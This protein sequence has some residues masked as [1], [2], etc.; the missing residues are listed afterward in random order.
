MKPSFALFL[1]LVASAHAVDFN[2][3]VRPVLAQQCF[4]CHGM[5]DHARKGK[6]RLDLS[7]SA[8]GKGKSGEIAIIPGKPDASE[9]IKRILST[10]EDEVMPP[11]HT[12]KVMSDKDKA[13]LKAWIAEGAKYQAHWAYSAPKQ[14]PVPSS[15]F[16]V[17]GSK[18][19]EPQETRNKKP[20]THPIDAFIHGRLEKEGLKPSPEAAAYTLVRRVYLDLIGLPP[21]PAE[22]D[23]FV[24]QSHQSPG[25]HKPYE[26]LVDT[27]LASKH[28]GERWAR[29]WLDLARYA[30]TNGFEKDRPRQIW[31][32]RDWVV[33]ALND[34]MPFDQFS[35]KQIAGDMLPKASAEDLIATGFHRNTMLNEEGGIDPNEY[36]FYAMVDR[37]GVTGTAWMGLTLNCCQCHTHKYDPILH[38]DYYSVMALLNNADEPL[39]HIPTPDIEAQQKAHAAKIAQLEAELPKKF[40]GGEAAMQ[41]RFAGW[42]EGESKRASKWQIVRPAAMK[43]TM[44]HLEQQT[45]GFILGSGDISKSDVYDLNLKAPIKGVTALRIEVASHPSLPND[46]PGLTNYEGPLGGFFLSEL[47]AFQN[48]QRVKITRAEATNDEEEDR[49]NDQSAAK[50]KAKAKAAAKPRKTNNA[51]AALDAEMSS[52]WQVLGGIGV[53]HAAVFHFEKPID[54]TSG[55]DLK[56][57]FEK[58]FACPLGH[59]RISVTT[60][61]HAIATGHPLEVEEALAANDSSKRE[62]LLRRFLETAP[63]MKQVTAPL[64]AARKNPP[65]G[66]PTLVMSERPASNPRPTNRYHRGEYLSP[67]ET[68]P[69]AVP[70][71]LP[72]LPK[73]APANRLTFAK[74]LFAPEN[75]LTARV[76]VNRQWQAFFG[77]G[78]VKSLEDFGYQSEPP[79]HPEL[80][81]WLAVEF[82]E[83]GWSMKKLHRLIVT[84]ATYK[85]SSRITPELAQ[86]DPENILLA[87]G[88]RF[89]LDA[90][91]I[92][93]SALK[94]AGVLSPKMGGPGVYPPQPASITSEGTYGK[95]EWKTSEGEDRY[96]RS[97]YTFIKRTAPFAMSTTFDAPTGE[98]CL[99]KRDVSN[100]PLQALTLLNDQ[101]FMEAAQAMAKAVIAESQDDDTRLQNIFRRCTTRPVAADELAML[102]TFL[103]KQRDQKLEGEALWAAV[104]RA[105]LNLDESITHP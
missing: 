58:H 17:S 88:A 97:L 12:K 76:T 1:L 29:R 5:D 70:A 69:P 31:P 85:Q 15:K 61:D 30:D 93:D 23:A 64:L 47:Q 39:Y 63:E 92:R 53:Q 3:D 34:D 98:A 22:A 77:R 24:H 16:Q 43:T 90:E 104:S 13:T 87:R 105:A 56:M 8:H 89:R 68:V 59:F 7:E 9:V 75:S 80:L 2:R 36:R 28:Y 91:I 82:V 79:S 25:S 67:K 73:D 49:I 86:R 42:I 81:D 46:G 83:L 33:K 84:S 72:S 32:Y 71:F 10:D 11:P 50:P 52:G 102:K 101:M 65:R 41:S 27:L 4:T 20:E 38:T 37:V 19:G 35:I 78:L 66:Q 99:A 51:S 44:P 54:L 55:F 57:L 48:G 95:F 45:N 94:A 21:T 18:S 40:P 96:R 14:G 62:V 74:W 100:S 26:K 60:S 6:L 103:Q